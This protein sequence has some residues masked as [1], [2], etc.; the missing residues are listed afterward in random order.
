MNSTFFIDIVRNMC[1]DECPPKTL[2]NEDAKTCEDC[3]YNC[4]SC[5][6]FTEYDCIE[7]IDSLTKFK[8]PD[9]KVICVDKDC[10]EG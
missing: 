5:G 9:G 1:L 3:S 10:P 8:L 4:K 2:Y 7:C 6:G